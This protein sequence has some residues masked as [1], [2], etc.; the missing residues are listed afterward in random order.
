MVIR[1]G[2]DTCKIE[3]QRPVFLESHHIHK[4]PFRQVL[5]RKKV[6]RPGKGDLYRFYIRN[7]VLI[8]TPHHKVN[9]LGV[10]PFILK[11]RVGRL[12]H[13]IGAV[14]QGR[15]LDKFQLNGGTVGH[16]QGNGGFAAVFHGRVSF[17]IDA[18]QQIAVLHLAGKIDISHPRRQIG[19]GS[20]LRDHYPLNGDYFRVIIVKDRK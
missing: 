15:P 10:I 11:L 19:F 1:T 9:F 18:Q 8:P 13:S 2:Q 7:S 6:V 14:C 5:L 12:Q 20:H 4:C 3:H 16:T 17:N